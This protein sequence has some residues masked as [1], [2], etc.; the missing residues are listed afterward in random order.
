M[1]GNAKGEKLGSSENRNQIYLGHRNPEGNAGHTRRVKE[2]TPQM[3]REVRKDPGEPHKIKLTCMIYWEGKGGR[4]QRQLWGCIA[5]GRKPVECQGNLGGR[6]LF[7]TKDTVERKNYLVGRF[8]FTRT[9][10]GEALDTRKGGQAA[11]GWPVQGVHRLC[12]RVR[13]TG[14]AIE[15]IK[16]LLPKG[17]PILGKSGN[18]SSRQAVSVKHVQ[19]TTCRGIRRD[20]EHVPKKASGGSP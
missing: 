16:R 12:Q 8:S 17:K 1:G 11:K 10:G 9:G 18:Q 6:K 4:G 19:S 5:T 3:G 13:L 15:A 20:G 2:R 14:G 7:V